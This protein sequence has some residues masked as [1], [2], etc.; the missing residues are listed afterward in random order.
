MKLCIRSLHRR[1][2]NHRT[3]WKVCICFMSQVRRNGTIDY[4]DTGHFTVEVTPEFRDTY[5][6]AFNPTQLGANAV[7]GSLVLDDGSF[8]FPVHS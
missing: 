2:N 3:R 6:Y 8:R 7:L 4:A 5:T 1:L